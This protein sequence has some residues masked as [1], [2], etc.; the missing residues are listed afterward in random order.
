M[1][2]IGSG[3]KGVSAALNDLVLA[4]PL[5]RSILL[6]GR[7][8]I[9]CL[10]E[11]QL[12]TPPP[13]HLAYGKCPPSPTSTCSEH[14]ANHILICSQQPRQARGKGLLLETA[15]EGIKVT[16]EHRPA[17]IGLCSQP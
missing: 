3:G 12:S 11:D 9:P 1:F 2:V 5:S 10:P 13:N 15:G 16:T 14:P 8:P 6:V 7:K 4:L 17:G